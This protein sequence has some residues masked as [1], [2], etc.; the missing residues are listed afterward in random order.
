MGL[1]APPVRN[2]DARVT[3]VGRL[4]VFSDG[5]ALRSSRRTSSRRQPTGSIRCLAVTIYGQRQ[6][7]SPVVRVLWEPEAWRRAFGISSREI[8]QG[9]RQSRETRRR[10]EQV[11][12]VF[13]DPLAVKVDDSEHS[14][15]A[16]ERWATLG[17]SE[18]GTLFAVIHTFEESSI[19]S[20]TVR[21]ISAR[22]ATKQEVRDYEAPAR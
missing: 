2:A 10:F 4:A 7:G 3:A 20:A 8:R 13:R 1:L 17:R 12:T 14:V 22:R 5:R 18:S 21:I 9:A 16:E 11:A 6:A 19:N 15:A